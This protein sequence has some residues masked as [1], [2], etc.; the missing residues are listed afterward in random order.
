MAFRIP[1]LCPFLAKNFNENSMAHVVLCLFLP[2]DCRALPASQARYQSKWQ[3]PK[4]W[5]LPL[6]MRQAAN[7]PQHGANNTCHKSKHT[8][9]S[10]NVQCANAKANQFL[11]THI[12]HVTLHIAFER[13]L[14]C[15]RAIFLFICSFA[16][17]KNLIIPDRAMN[18]NIFIQMARDI[19]VMK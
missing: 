16:S 3:K 6:K 1:G 10:H 14:H 2:N 5:Q 13:L 9:R 15:C 18:N 8:T 19:Q 12:S 4:P 7:I 11:H 17:K